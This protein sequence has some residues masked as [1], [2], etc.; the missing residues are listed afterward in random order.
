MKLGIRWK[1]ILSFVLVVLV[2]GVP[3][4]IVVNRILF[5]NLTSSQKERL[6]GEARR[7]DKTLRQR[8]E[9][10]LLKACTLS[11]DKEILTLTEEGKYEILK[12]RLKSLR[13]A[14]ELDVLEI[15]D[16]KGKMTFALRGEETS[17]DK[18]YDLIFRK[19]LRGISSQEVAPQPQG[20]EVR[21]AVPLK[22]RQKVVGCLLAGYQLGE[23]F[24]KE[25]KYLSGLDA[26]LVF[27]GEV[28]TST[29]NI[30]WKDMNSRAVFQ[31]K[32]VHKFKPFLFDLKIGGQ[33]YYTLARP[34]YFEE[35]GSHAGF[36][37]TLISA[38]PT[39]MAVSKAQRNVLLISL[40]GALLAILLG[41]LLSRGFSDPLLQ[42]T[43][44][45][46][47]IAEGD[48]KKT[49]EIKREDEIGVLSQAFQRM[50]KKLRGIID[51]QQEQIN[52]LL[53]GV[54]TAAKGDLTK[55]VQVEGEDEFGELG[56][57]FNKMIKNLSGLVGQINS[58]V[59]QVNLSTDKILS[60][61][62]HQTSGVSEQASETN[63]VASSLAELTATS[64]QI[65][66]TAQL[67]AKQ[68]EEA[69]QA[70]ASGV[71]AVKSSVTSMEEISRSA[72]NTARKIKELGESSK[73]I[74]KVVSTIQ[75]VAEQ[76]NLLSLNAA[77]EAARAGEQ[78]RGF[79]VVA[80]EVRKLAER[81]AQFAEEIRALIT[82]IQ[83][84]VKAT[85]M[86]VENE[87]KSVEEGVQR[88][89]IAGDSLK[90]IVQLVEQT[91]ELGKEISLSTEE[92]TSGSAQVADTVSN[93][94]QMA[95]STEVF[96]RQTEEGARDLAQLA[97]KLE[98]AT[99][100]LK[101]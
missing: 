37:V 86:A 94:S 23:N 51:Y 46:T 71:E 22:K 5:A 38:K 98:E 2:L 8:T 15:V 61:A 21:A 74:G 95:K 6:E 27:E 90:R 41:I 14:M 92:Q 101:V 66:Q 30:P 40:L 80:D 59:N 89:S 35:N 54:A 81:S 91:A 85:V 39:L 10:V 7:L 16:Q 43:Q 99:K 56:K 53:S 52:K 60:A 97:K 68:A 32:E 3:A 47:Q 1:L 28:I 88:I 33:P 18:P 75:G 73:E 100:E 4:T 57:Q 34:V 48:L 69:N 49:V 58:A 64:K 9:S 44:T 19:A 26:G 78:G 67:V 82:N 50:T 29:L 36:V 76:I 12:K 96:A 83:E 17:K 72:Q 87:T 55:Q 93:L 20:F 13:S 31:M 62:Q 25:M 24:I 45:A 79:A 11:Q 84:G 65:A 63:Q 70:A 42:L 77:I